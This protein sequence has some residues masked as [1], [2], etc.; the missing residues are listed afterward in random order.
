MVDAAQT[1]LRMGILLKYLQ[2]VDQNMEI[3]VNFYIIFKNKKIKEKLVKEVI[4]QLRGDI[5]VLFG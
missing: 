2:K 5:I 1:Y 4:P 3:M